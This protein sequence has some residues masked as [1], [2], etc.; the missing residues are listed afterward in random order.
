MLHIASP[1]VLFWGNRLC[2]IFSGH[3]T[4]LDGG[5]ILRFIEQVI[6]LS[7]IRISVYE[8]GKSAGHLT[9]LVEKL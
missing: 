3:Y 2:K 1:A 9:V 8:R 5:S 6:P 4:P 7:C